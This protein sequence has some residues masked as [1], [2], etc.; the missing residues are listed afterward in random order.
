MFV[1]TE[2]PLEGSV[3]QFA[4]PVRFSD[5]AFTIERHAPM[6]GE[7]TREILSESGYGDQ[8]IDDLEAAGII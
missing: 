3:P 2:H 1:M 6:H 8:Q 7:H 4:F 5:F